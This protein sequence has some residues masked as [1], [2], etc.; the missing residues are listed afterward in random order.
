MLLMTCAYVLFSVI[1]LV[2]TL[3]V[4][5][6]STKAMTLQHHLV[7]LGRLGI[8]AAVAMGLADLLQTGEP[9][10]WERVLMVLALSMVYVGQVR[11]EVIRQRARQRRIYRDRVK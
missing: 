6:L 8:F 9:P 4:N 3:S 10:E 11:C 1:T 7:G 2:A 5:L